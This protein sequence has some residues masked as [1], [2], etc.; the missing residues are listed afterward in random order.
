MAVGSP[1]DNFD[2][3]QSGFGSLQWLLLK[4]LMIF[5]LTDASLRKRYLTAK[6]HFHSYAQDTQLHLSIKPKTKERLVKLQV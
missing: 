2:M 1:A 3:F 6:I 4:S 5:P